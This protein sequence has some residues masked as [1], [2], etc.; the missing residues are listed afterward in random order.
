[1]IIGVCGK[2]GSGKSTISNEIVGLSNS[3]VHLDID[4]VGHNVLLIPEVQ[5]ELVN[6]FGEEI[7]N[8]N[9]VDRKKLGNLV[10]NSRSEMDKLS[11]IT[12]KYMMI[13]IDNFL[14]TNKDKII[15]LDWILL[16]ITKYFEMC[17]IKIL[18]DIPYEIR[19]ERAIK[20]DNITKDA[21]ALREKASVD[22]NENDFDYILRENNKDELFNLIVQ[23][24]GQ[25]NNHDSLN[26]IPSNDSENIARYLDSFEY[27]KDKSDMILKNMKD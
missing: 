4:A 7:I 21:F 5:K 15:V 1:M 11:E 23:I 2:S 3:A 8:E 26:I 9:V 14:E 12:W 16:R 25:N 10:F 13:E 19:M 27:N 20:R 22:F 18:L 24:F 6:Y 17:D